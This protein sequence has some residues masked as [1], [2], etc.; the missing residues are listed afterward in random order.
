MLN[1]KNVKI[2]MSIQMQTRS[3]QIIPDVPS[4]GAFLR[5]KL[6]QNEHFFES[7]KSVLFEAILIKIDKHIN[8]KHSKYI[9][10]ANSIN[11]TIIYTNDET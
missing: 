2:G 3:F 10:Y 9:K 6:L 8:A 11:K 4:F 7:S 5:L 1:A